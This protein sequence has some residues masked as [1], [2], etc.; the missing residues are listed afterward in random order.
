MDHTRVQLEAEREA[1]K[2]ANYTQVK[3]LLKADIE[4][5]HSYL[6]YA[7]RPMTTHCI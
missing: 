3:Q 7:V 5:I 4:E 1:G 2:Q 6:K